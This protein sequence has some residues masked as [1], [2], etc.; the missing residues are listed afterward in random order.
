MCCSG[1]KTP[2]KIA[3]ALISAVETEN[4]KAL[5]CLKELQFS[6]LVSA[7]CFCAFRCVLS[8]VN[9]EGLSHIEDHLSSTLSRLNFLGPHF[10]FSGQISLCAGLNTNNV[11]GN[12]Y[13]CSSRALYRWNNLKLFCLGKK[14]KLAQSFSNNILL[15]V[16]IFRH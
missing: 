2:L 12:N 14:T 8:Q 7:F 5:C 1:L 11:S 16:K 6:G 3:L 13:M 9:T 10:S 15:G 4:P